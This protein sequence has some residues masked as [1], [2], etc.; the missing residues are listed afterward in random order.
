MGIVLPESMTP[1]IIQILVCAGVLA[2]MAPIIWI[3]RARERRR[4]RSRM[5]GV[6]GLPADA[7][8][9]LE[10]QKPLTVRERIIQAV[11][12]AGASGGA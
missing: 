12:Y 2:I 7:W 9:K 6:A 4:W 11:A 1:P 3:S 10:Q 5:D 8:V